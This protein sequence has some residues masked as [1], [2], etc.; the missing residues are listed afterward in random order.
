MD[1]AGFLNQEGRLVEATGA[2]LLVEVDATILTP[3]AWDGALPSIMVD[4][5]ER[6]AAKVGI[7]FVREPIPLATARAADGISLAGRWINWWMS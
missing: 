3:P 4:T 5:V 7:P 2:A 6:I 1:D